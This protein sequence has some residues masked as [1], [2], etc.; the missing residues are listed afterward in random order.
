MSLKRRLVIA[1]AIIVL[2]V[3]VA[4]S[5]DWRLFMLTGRFTH[6]NIVEVLNSPIAV[7]NVKEDGLLAFD[8]RTLPLPGVVKV[9]VPAS[10]VK[11]I[12]DHG[13]EVKPDGS[14]YALVR[15]HHWCGN[16]P[17]HVHLAR[18]DLS[19]L[20]LIL[21]EEAHFRASDY[22]IDPALLSM[23]SHSHDEILKVIE[24]P[25]SKP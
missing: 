21:G 5:L 4:F 3:T 6:I 9:L 25:T 2:G 15:V 1:G 19:S 11:D 23:A 16:D 20:V 24:A 12:L 14:I 22:G 10:V 13:V 7:A 17:V 18:V 8:G